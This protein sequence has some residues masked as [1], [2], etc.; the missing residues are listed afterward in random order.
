MKKT[1]LLS[2]V[3]STM[4]M[5]GGDIEPVA[6]APVVEDF[7]IFSN[8][9]A[10]GEIRPRYEYVNVDNTRDDA[11]AFTSR[12]ALGLHA[13]LFQIEGL[14]TYLEATSVIGAGDYD[15][16]RVDDSK[17]YQ[18][19]ADPNQTRITQA[20][21][22][23][24]FSDTL[25]RAGRQGVNLDNQRFIGTVNW[26]QMPQTYDAVA[27][28][29]N[30]V[31][32]LNLLAAYV[33]QVNR[34]FDKDSRKVAPVIGITRGDQLETNS[35]LLHAAYTF[36]PEL[37][38]TGYGYLIQDISDTWGIAA[39][40]KF[41]VGE[42]SK[43]A[44]RAEYAHQADPSITDYLPD[45]TADADYYNIQA[46]LN[47][48]GFLAGARYEVLGA[49]NNNNGSFQTP[50]ATLHGQNGWAD[51]FL[52]TPADGLVDVNGMLGYK[53]AGFGVAKVVYHDFSSD[54]GSTDYGTEVDALYK[55]KVPGVKGLTGMLKAAWYSADNYAADTTKV[56]AMLDYKF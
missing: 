1:L 37:T 2:V 34:I 45:A 46:T 17:E 38:V 48:S 6:T 10:N 26:R 4:M 52:A 7:L 12:V 27:V 19:V 32:N 44:Y 36:M 25:I 20:Y 5:A 31:E 11:N 51:M 8:I 22:D 16:L 56:W 33:W 21:V 18:V 29:N 15:S 28:I 24:K 14:S 35:V 23:Y 9:T 30:S 54:T 49:G 13:D 53:S 47:M 55:N 41:N 3:A 43:I 50:L 42:A 40:G 39:T